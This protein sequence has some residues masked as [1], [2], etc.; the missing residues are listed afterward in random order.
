MRKRKVKVR[1]L[2]LPPAPQAED[3]R[4]QRY[5]F[6]PDVKRARSDKLSADFY[7]VHGRDNTV[8]GEF[9]RESPLVEWDKQSKRDE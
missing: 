1:S 3:S 8:L 9:E 6:D 7:R 2:R 4:F 5:M